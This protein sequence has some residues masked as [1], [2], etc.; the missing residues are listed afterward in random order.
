MKQ[1]E[2]LYDAITDIREDIVLGAEQHKFQIKRRRAPRWAASIA[3][4]LAV[5]IAVTA[6]AWPS[7][8]S[9]VKAYAIAEAVY[10]E[11]AEYPD[12]NSS[13]F[14]AQYDAWWED[15]R[16]QRQPEGYANGLED[17]FADSIQAFL[18]DANGENKV[19]SPLNVY[20]ALCMLSELTDGNS[21]QQILD[22]LGCGSIQAVRQQANQVWNANYQNDGATTSILASSLWLNE[23]VSFDPSTMDRLAETYYASS[24]Q[25][26]MGS[27][28]LNLALQNWLN[29]QTNGLLENQI[30]EIE[31]DAGTILAL[32][33]T[34]SYRAKWSTEFRDSY[35][36]EDVFHGTAGDVT[37]EYMHQSPDQ[38]Y[39]WGDQFAAVSKDLKSYGHMWFI[40]P[41]E[42][43]TPEELLKNQQV[44]DF[45]T[46]DGE[47]AESK[48]LIV[49]LSIPK[50]DVSSQMELKGGMMQLGI[51]DVFD[52]NTSDFSPTTAAMEGIYLS[53]AA[54]G[55]RVAIDEEGVIAAAYTVMVEPSAA[56]PPEDEV[57]FVL[58][59][60]F[61]FVITGA[62]GE[63]M[64]VGI[65][66]RI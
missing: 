32:A 46:S 36:T 17:F 15:I 52:A 29:E 54:H 35:N 61:L 45:I 41:D 4:V 33:T 39:Y 34:I 6:V 13:R 43:V 42:G 16:A 49:N 40:L 53:Q 3:A 59:R 5:A 9:V 66:N 31:L 25:G 58:D 56:E 38:E 24:Y 20:M 7:S 8:Q 64:F 12:E 23:D 51:T 14:D 50:F 47:S 44:L 22:A 55:A 18:G 62:A 19:Y 37:V 48:R 30:G 63:P 21:R 1:S 57:D 2:K 11:M 60:P 65:V 10:P 28:E 27:E 26:K